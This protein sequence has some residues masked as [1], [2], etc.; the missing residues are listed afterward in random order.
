MEQVFGMVNQLL[1]KN[2]ETRKR[3]LKMRTYKVWAETIFVL[4]FVLN[5]K[6]SPWTFS[7]D[8]LSFLFKSLLWSWV[9]SSHTT[10]LDLLQVSLEFLDRS[11]F[12]RNDL[13]SLIS[14]HCSDFTNSLI[15][16]F[17]HLSFCQYYWWQ[18]T[19]KF[20][21]HL[22]LF[23]L[24]VIP[25]SQRS[26]IVEWCEDTVPLGEY[27]IG[28]PGTKTGAH[29]RYYPGDWTSLEC[30]K[31]IQVQRHCP[32]HISTNIVTPWNQIEGERVMCQNSLT[33][34]GN[35]IL[36]FRLASDQVVHLET[37]ASK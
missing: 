4:L 1:I 18:S 19:F 26:G 8:F 3:K 10:R 23:L 32:K 29:P 5:C 28:R 12:S 16:I 34:S 11:S 9:N 21:L 6:N 27:L 31:K 25:L 7:R 17:L 33:P 15:G 14:V 35:N 2:S 22:Q 30:R 36:N 24:Q 37:A 20:H 13:F